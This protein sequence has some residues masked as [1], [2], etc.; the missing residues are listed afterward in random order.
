LR[1]FGE[2]DNQWIISVR[3]FHADQDSIG[4]ADISDDGNRVVTGSDRGRVTLWNTK[5]KAGTS[6][7]QQTSERELLNVH[8]FPSLVRFVK[9]GP[10]ESNVIAFEKASEEG[11]AFVF[12]TDK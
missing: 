8:R 2:Q 1:K 11:V 4:A 12:P 3:L 9:F 6:D 7:D 5:T 10:H